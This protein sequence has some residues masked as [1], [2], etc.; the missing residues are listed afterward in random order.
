MK[1]KKG[2]MILLLVRPTKNGTTKSLPGRIRELL[3]LTECKVFDDFEDLLHFIV[4][5]PAATEI[6]ILQAA[7][8]DDLIDFQRIRNCAL[9]LQILLVVPDRKRQTL[10]WAHRLHPRYVASAESNFDNLISVLAKM[11]R[12]NF[13]RNQ[14]DGRDV[15]LSVPILS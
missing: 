15:K 12:N 8:Q 4:P 6:T 7:S 2:V 14:A 11:L 3:P 13:Q 5:T 9:D 10:F 1:Y